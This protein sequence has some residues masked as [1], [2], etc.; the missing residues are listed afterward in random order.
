MA[1]DVDGSGVPDAEA[2]GGLSAGPPGAAPGATKL[3][4]FEWSAIR[5]RMRRIYRQ[6]RP[7]KLG[8]IDE[9]LVEWAGEEQQLLESIVEKYGAGPDRSPVK[10]LKV[11]ERAQKKFAGARAKR[12]KETPAEK[13]RR[14]A[15]R[16]RAV[17]RI[18]RLVR[19][20]QGRR[21]AAARAARL[22]AGIEDTPSEASTEVSSQTESDDEPE[23]AGEPAPEALVWDA[24]AQRYRAAGPEPEKQSDAELFRALSERRKAR[25]PKASPAAAASPK[26]P[27]K[28]SPKS[29]P[30]KSAPAAKAPAKVPAKASAKPAP[31]ARAQRVVVDGVPTL[32]HRQRSPNKAPTS[33]GAKKRK[34][35]LRIVTA[36]TLAQRRGRATDDGQALL[37]KLAVARIEIGWRMSVKTKRRNRHAAATEMQRYVRGW[38][39]RSHLAELLAARTIQYYLRRHTRALVHQRLSKLKAGVV[40][41]QRRWLARQ[42]QRIDT[43][44]AIAADAAA[45][46]RWRTLRLVAKRDGRQCAEEAAAVG[47]VWSERAAR[48]A[49]DKAF[50]ELSRRCVAQAARIGA[51]VR[52]N[53]AVSVVKRSVI[54]RVMKRRLYRRINRRQVAQMDTMRGM[55]LASITDVLG[56]DEASS[57][58]GLG[59]TGR[60]VGS[61]KALVPSD[62]ATAISAGGASAAASGSAGALSPIA[63]AGAPRRNWR[64]AKKKSALLSVATSRAANGAPA[65]GYVQ[66]RATSRA[67]L[68]PLP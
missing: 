66:P 18:Q 53:W 67:R 55:L 16:V 65:A 8:D 64:K 28:V 6:H 13:V 1:A 15:Q 47:R 41:L 61:H 20:R 37:R 56:D 44:R 34:P 27:P 63:A 22:A 40:T 51:V 24:G 5:V 43:L 54:R 29:V 62:A 4:P 14:A 30:A 59:S 23:S 2:A 3:T 50:R 26:A 7:E 19:G 42:R 57:I 9:L 58:M 39:A 60:S 68:V 49:A 31:A 52:W 17:V 12:K 45:E 32:Q 25:S 35:R 11:L 21:A 46:A 48:R 36:A 38:I 10:G 33:K